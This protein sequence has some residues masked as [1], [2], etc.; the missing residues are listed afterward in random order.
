MCPQLD[1]ESHLSIQVLL[2]Q[3]AHRRLLGH[4]FCQAPHSFIHYMGSE[5]YLASALLPGASL[6]FLFPKGWALP[7]AS[8]EPVVLSS[9]GWRNGANTRDTRS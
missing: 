5:E 1:L 6:R 7:L 2:A 9:Q 4:T 3:C 8:P